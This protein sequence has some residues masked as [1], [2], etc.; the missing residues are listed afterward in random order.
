MSPPLKGN[1]EVKEVKETKKGKKYGYLEIDGERYSCW[2]LSKISDVARGDTVDFTYKEND[3][4][5][6]NLNFIR[7]TKPEASAKD[8][9]IAKSVCLKAAT[10]LITQLGATAES[11]PNS[12]DHRKAL[13]LEVLDVA[14]LFVDSLF[15]EAD[16]D[17]DSPEPQEPSDAE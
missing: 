3:D 1:V 10:D 16:S 12:A 9:H 13:A 6:R 17:K 11:R 7:K 14:N 2:D 5:F 4:G 15:Q 8:T